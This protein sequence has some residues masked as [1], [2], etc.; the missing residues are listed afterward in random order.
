ML[1]NLR[2]ALMAGRRTPTARDYV[3]NGLVAMWDGIENAGWGTHDA[4]TTVWKDLIG[5]RDLTCPSSSDGLF[6]SNCWRQIS[7]SLTEFKMP[8]SG[9]CRF[10]EGYRYITLEAVM[11]DIS[12][13]YGPHAITSEGGSGS[14]GT[15]SGISLYCY[16]PD[17]ITRQGRTSVGNGTAWGYSIYY[18]DIPDI[19]PFHLAISIDNT[20]KTYTQYLDG[21][22]YGHTWESGGNNFSLGYSMD[23]R[24]RLFTS[25]SGNVDCVKG[26]CVRVY[27]RALTASEIAANYAIDKARFGLP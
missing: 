17:Q 8:T 13:R 25:S 24:V 4:S 27:S 11:S 20:N 21:V 18:G 14:A 15:S 1:I 3:Q 10:L 26:F 5:N 23:T 9:L 6:E 7:S 19:T 22:Q 2:N 12:T 16:K